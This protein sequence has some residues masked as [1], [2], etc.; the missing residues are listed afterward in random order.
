MGKKLIKMPSNIKTLEIFKEWSESF[1]TPKSILE[2]RMKRRQ[3]FE[4]YHFT[5]YKNTD[6]IH[7]DKVHYLISD[8]VSTGVCHIRNFNRIFLF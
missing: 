2:I 8:S 4:P 7:G 3:Q 1:N 5:K 6:S